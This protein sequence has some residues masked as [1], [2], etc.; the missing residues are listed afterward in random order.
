M[1]SILIIG[2][3]WLGKI[4]ASILL[5]SSY[6]VTGTTRSKSN[7]DALSSLG[8]SPLECD[9]HLLSS[10][11]IPKFDVIIISI[12]PNRKNGSLEYAQNI[13]LLSKSI[14]TTNAQVIMCSSTSVYDGFLGEVTEHD[15]KPTLQSTIPVLL[16][17]AELKKWIPSTVILRLGG[18]YGYDRHPVYY[19]SGRT[20]IPNGNAPVNLVHGHDVASVLKLI[21]EKEI[22]SQIYN[23][24]AP[25]HPNKHQVYTS[26]AK[27]F[28]IEE[29][30]FLEGGK[31]GKIVISDKLIQSLNYRFKYPNPMK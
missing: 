25:N 27:E 2:C 16:A 20:S 26:K 29:P 1:K 31:N 18:L 4:T 14:S 13:H 12:P 17:E 9:I 23:V 8:I 28:G 30:Q 19:L 6:L 10:F 22:T 21:I 11:V 15:Q 3:G 24:V 5:S 7:F